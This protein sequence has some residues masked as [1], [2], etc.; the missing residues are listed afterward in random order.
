MVSVI[1]YAELVGA[2][3][4]NVSPVPETNGS[5]VLLNGAVIRPLA[6]TVPAAGAVLVVLSGESVYAWTAISIDLASELQAAWALWPVTLVEREDDRRSK[7]AE[8]NDDDEQFDQG[9]P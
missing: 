3:C 2:A 9:E 5:P 8:D 7:D 1:A 6:A 4:R